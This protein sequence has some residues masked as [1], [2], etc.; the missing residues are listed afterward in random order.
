M[1]HTRYV[2]KRTDAYNQFRN[3]RIPLNESIRVTVKKDRMR[4]I[5]SRNAAALTLFAGKV[6]TRCGDF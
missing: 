6:Y 5:N 1:P 4:I 2:K 3:L